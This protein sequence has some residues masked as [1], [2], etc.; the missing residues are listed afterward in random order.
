[1]KIRKLLNLYRVPNVWKDP[2][3]LL[4]LDNRGNNEAKTNADH[5]RF[6]KK[7]ITDNEQRYMK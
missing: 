5:K 2:T 3:L 6:W 7:Y 1:M 4:N